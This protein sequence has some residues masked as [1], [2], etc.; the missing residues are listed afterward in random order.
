MLGQ[1]VVIATEAEDE[2]A[3]LSNVDS[4]SDVLEE[5][6][7]AF[8][9]GQRRHVALRQ[10]QMSAHRRNIIRASVVHRTKVQRF[11][12]PAGAHTSQTE[13]APPTERSGRSSS[14]ERQDDISPPP[15]TRCPPP[16][17][18]P[19]PPPL[20]TPPPE[21]EERTLVMYCSRARLIYRPICLLM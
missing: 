17:P 9:S 3:G 20:T 19:L 8:P 12:A 6:G 7:E 1:A 10:S 14:P 18:P 15:E 2:V 4:V 21:A 13:T 5:E 16:R 11:K